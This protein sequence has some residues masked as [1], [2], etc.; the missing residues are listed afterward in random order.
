MPSEAL[1]KML[2][3]RIV[4]C[5]LPRMKV[6]PAPGSKLPDLLKAMTLPA[7]GVSPPIRAPSTNS[8]TPEPLLPS[9]SVPAR[10][11]PMK[12]PWMTLATGWPLE[13]IVP[14][15]VS[16]GRCCPR[17]RCRPRW[18]CHRRC[19]R[20]QGPRCRPPPKRCRCRCPGPRCRGVDA[21]EVAD[22]G[23][24]AR[25]LE[26]NPVPLVPRDHVPRA[27]AVPPTVFPS[28]K[29]KKKMPSR[30]FGMPT[31]PVESVPM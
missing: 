6:T 16:R 30:S 27:G 10:S 8:F 5:L 19:W 31:V 2:L 20:C 18:R 12:L 22:D 15:N 23:V 29:P 28:M 7:A 24:A 17:S 25:R 26:G 4:S 9:G 21:D 13:L 1:R 14:R 3:V 11:V